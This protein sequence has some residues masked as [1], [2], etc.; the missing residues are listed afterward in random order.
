MGKIKKVEEIKI[1]EHKYSNEEILFTLEALRSSGMTENIRTKVNEVYRY[2]F[3]EDIV[4][5]CCKNRSYIKM[6]HY[7]RNTLKLI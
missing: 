5:S 3:N 2:L 6:E 1:T 7:V 4:Y